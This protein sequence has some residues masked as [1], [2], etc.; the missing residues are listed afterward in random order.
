MDYI[1]TPKY[2]KSTYDRHIEQIS[3]YNDDVKTLIIG[4]SIIERFNWFANKKFQNNVLLLAK[5]GDTTNNLMYILTFKE[6]PSFQNI[7]K[8]YFN[9]GANDINGKSDEIVIN[10]ILFVYDYLKKM[11]P[12]AIIKFIPLYH[13]DGINPTIINFINNGVKSKLK[14]D[15][16]DGFWDTI[17][18]NGYEKNKYEDHIH[19]NKESYDLFYNKLYALI[20]KE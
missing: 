10:D 5:G 7:T 4:N 18:P 16:L 9:T 3:K 12:K 8:I 15:Y 20:D 2:R 13:I 14:E 19:L 11:S 17:L 6:N 1:V